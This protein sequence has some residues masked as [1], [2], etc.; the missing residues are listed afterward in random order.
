MTGILRLLIGETPHRIS[1]S[2][3]QP[4]PMLPTAP[5]AEG[6]AAISEDE[7]DAL[8]ASLRGGEPLIW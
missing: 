5:S 3:I 2:A 6:M 8:R 4:P 7:T 1:Q